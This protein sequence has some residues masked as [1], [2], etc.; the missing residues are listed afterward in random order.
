VRMLRD[1]NWL[2]ENDWQQG[3]TS[4]IPILVAIPVLAT[5]TD[6]SWS[7][8]FFSGGFT[9]PQSIVY[10]DSN[11]TYLQLSG[12]PSAG[13]TDSGYQRV[14]TTFRDVGTNS[15]EVTSEVRWVEKTEARSY[16]LTAILY[17]WKQ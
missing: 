2:A 17:D 1:S 5:T 14:I 7:L 15:L 11:L 12:V 13:L 3:I 9:D 10:T 16:A 4:E 6:Y 8:F